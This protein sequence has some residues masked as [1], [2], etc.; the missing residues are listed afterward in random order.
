MP[1]NR[2]HRQRPTLPCQRLPSLAKFVGNVDVVYGRI[3]SICR[4][5]NIISQTWNW[6]RNL[7]ERSLVDDAEHFNGGSLQIVIV[8]EP[9]TL[10]RG[11]PLTWTRVEKRRALGS[12]PLGNEP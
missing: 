7:C 5:A 12:F 1:T 4:V 2:S 6:V 10:V 9:Q 11:A 3:E 8:C